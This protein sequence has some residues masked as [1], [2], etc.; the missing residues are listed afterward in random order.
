M[1]QGVYLHS[2]KCEMEL[3]VKKILYRVYELYKLGKNKE[4]IPK[5]LLSVFNNSDMTVEEYISLDD[6]TMFSLFT[7]WRESEDNILSMLCASFLDRKKFS[8]LDILNNSD[9]EIHSFKQELIKILGKHEY[10]IKDLKD[11]Y[12]WIE[13]KQKNQTYK[14]RKDNIWVL[15]E[16]GTICDL[17]EISK[18]VN[19]KLKDE[20]NMTFINFE[21]LK[22]IEQLNNEER[23]VEEIKELINAYH[24]RSH[25]EIEKKYCLIEGESFEKIVDILEEYKYY[26]LE[27]CGIKQQED[28]YYDTN[29]QILFKNNKTL[30]IRNRGDKYILTIKTP[31]KN[32]E[33]NSSG[34]DVGQNERFEYE[35]QVDSGDILRNAEYIIKYLPELKDKVNQ[36]ERSLTI[37]NNRKKLQLK[38][39]NVVFEM[40]FDD[41]NYIGRQ[42]VH[43]FQVEIELKSDYVHRINL[44]MLTDYL[45][46]K[47]SSLKPIYESKYKRGLVLTKSINN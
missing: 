22:E 9:D 34:E 40:V 20:I 32:H 26:N 6:T 16:N 5:P 37:I 39:R 35:I 27:D 41:V 36:L 3:I 11:E 31:T 7:T 33:L 8:K 14:D 45:E 15:R 17:F 44:K 4:Y 18:L 19:E 47:I 2:F 42:E 1:H 24:N 30:R 23:A 25:V 28:I 21:L 46:T 29:E 13:D 43:E 10:S 12:F 38:N